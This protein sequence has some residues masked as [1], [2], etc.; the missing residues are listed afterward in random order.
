MIF[1]QNHGQYIDFP[2]LPCTLLVTQA[3]L[4]RQTGCKNLIVASSVLR[5]ARAIVP[6]YW[7]LSLYHQSKAFHVY[8]P[9]YRLFQSFVYNVFPLNEIRL[10]TVHLFI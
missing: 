4:I 9:A 6:K 10:S 7:T 8:I 3:I 5:T 2:V 1:L